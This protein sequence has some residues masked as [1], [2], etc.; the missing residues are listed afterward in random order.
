MGTVTAPTSQGCLKDK[1]TTGKPACLAGPAALQ[2]S[3]LRPPRCFLSP[4]ALLTQF[5]VGT[6]LPP[7]TSQPP[8]LSD[9]QSPP[10]APP[11]PHPLPGPD[12]PHRKDQQLLMLAMTLAL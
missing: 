7:S 11:L 6:K 5:H 10:Q 8:L 12:P 9:R 1:T 4:Q 3:L 2:R